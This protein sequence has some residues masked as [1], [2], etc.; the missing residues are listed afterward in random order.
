MRRSVIRS[1]H[2]SRPQRFVP[3]LMRTLA[4]RPPSFD[5]HPDTRGFAVYLGFLHGHFNCRNKLVAHYERRDVL[6]PGFGAM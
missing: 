4:S 2:G 5:H 3:S 6:R 1:C